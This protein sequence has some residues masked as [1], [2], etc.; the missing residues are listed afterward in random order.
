MNRSKYNVININLSN[1]RVHVY[2]FFLMKRVL[3]L[4]C[5]LMKLFSI[6]YILLIVHIILL[7]LILD[8]K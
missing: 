6:T 3:L 1:V 4:V 8:H 2:H 5:S 7:V